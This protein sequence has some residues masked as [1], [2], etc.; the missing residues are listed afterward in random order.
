M[1]Q[2]VPVVNKGRGG[3]HGVESVGGK[4]KAK[5]TKY[6]QSPSKKSNQEE[7]P[8]TSDD[9]LSDYSFDSQGSL[10]ME[11]LELNDDDPEEEPEPPPELTE[12]EKIVGFE[13]SSRGDL[14]F[15]GTFYGPNQMDDPYFDHEEIELLG[16]DLVE[17]DLPSEPK[18][19]QLVSEIYTHSRQGHEDIAL[20]KVKQEKELLRLRARKYEVYGWFSYN[21]G[22]GVVQVVAIAFFLPMLLRTLAVQ[23]A[24]PYVG[25]PAAGTIIRCPYYK[26]PS[27]YTGGRYPTFTQLQ[28]SV[29]GDAYEKLRGF[30]LYDLDVFYTSRGL[31][32]TSFSGPA[33]SVYTV[34]NFSTLPTFVLTQQYR[35]LKWLE[36]GNVERGNTT[37]NN[38]TNST[39]TTQ[40][41]I[42]ERKVILGGEVES[43]F[44]ATNET[45]TFKNATNSSVV[46][47]QQNGSFEGNVSNSSN[48]SNISTLCRTATEEIHICTSCI[49]PKIIWENIL[50]TE[51]FINFSS[52]ME[53]AE[54]PTNVSVYDSVGG[55]VE[56]MPT[57]TNLQNR[58]YRG[59]IELVDGYEY[60]EADGHLN[61]STTCMLTFNDWGALRDEHEI[62][63]LPSM[64]WIHNPRLNYSC[65]PTAKKGNASYALTVPM[66]TTMNSTVY[67][68][69]KHSQMEIEF[70]VYNNSHPCDNEFECTPSAIWGLSNATNRSDASPL[71]AW[72]LNVSYPYALNLTDVTVEFLVNSSNK[73][74]IRNE[75]V[76]VRQEEFGMFYLTVKPEKWRFGS[77]TITVEIKGAE[78]FNCSNLNS[79]NSSLCNTTGF[80][81]NKTSA[82]TLSNTLESERNGS[83]LRN[84][85]FNLTH[86]RL[87]TAGLRFSFTVRVNETVCGHFVDFWVWRIRAV[88]YPQH[89][90]FVSFLA[91]LVVGLLFG[92]AGDY[93]CL[94]RLG[95]FAFSGFGSFCLLTFYFW[96]R[97]QDYLYAGI[98][99]VVL[100]AS[101]GTAA[102]YHNA[103]L[104]RLV[105]ADL[106]LNK[107]LET[108]NYLSDLIP[109]N[110]QYDEMVDRVS[111]QAFRLVYGFGAFGLFASYMYIAWSQYVS[112]V[113]DMSI[114][115]FDFLLNRLKYTQ[116]CLVE[117]SVND[118]SMILAFCGC[119]MGFFVLVNSSL[120]WTRWGVRCNK[121]PIWANILPPV[122]WMAFSI[123]KQGQMYYREDEWKLLKQSWKVL[124]LIFM[125][126]FCTNALTF[127]TTVL[128]NSEFHVNDQL[129]EDSVLKISHFFRM[130][131]LTWVLTISSWLGLRCF[132]KLQVT[133]EM[134]HIDAFMF[135]TALFQ[136]FMLYAL[137]ANFAE[138]PFG[139]KFVEEAYALTFFHGLWNG[140]LYAYGRSAFMKVVP[141]GFDAQFFT[142]YQ[143]AT[144]VNGNSWLGAKMVDN[145][146][147]ATGTV[148]L[149]YLFLFLFVMCI[150]CTFC[151]ACLS[152]EHGKRAA[153]ALT[154]VVRQRKF[155]KSWKHL[156]Q[157]VKNRHENAAVSVWQLPDLIHCMHRQVNFVDAIDKFALLHPKCSRRNVVKKA[158][159]ICRRE[160]QD[161]TPFFMFQKNKRPRV[162]PKFPFM[163]HIEINQKLYKMWEKTDEEERAVFAQKAEAEAGNDRLRYYVK[164]NVLWQARYSF[165]LKKL[166]EFAPH[167]IQIQRIARG[168]LCRKNVKPIPSVALEIVSA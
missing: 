76:N 50:W 29:P 89:V 153:R 62:V 24:C 39:W 15:D 165:E 33:G 94:R 84:L 41:C 133:F 32:V 2:I 117:P 67:D 45:V 140:P 77:S 120:S 102:V 146:F 56:R 57:Y 82:S 83:S 135:A 163:S 137:F 107:L 108:M 1:S 7:H 35:R 10:A 30:L 59:G 21:A 80:H 103:Y 139:L 74:L 46:C 113:W 43:L 87:E 37:A 110:Q 168:F 118:M 132:K 66:N 90:F 36:Y 166:P 4:G 97:P 144:G 17:I 78:P 119:W 126:F 136:F 48:S 100:V 27:N 95:L 23:Y 152:V 73:H 72:S 121:M 127:T 162:E 40:Q 164:R 88:D 134:L 25:L 58:S 124:L 38:L 63:Y 44:N 20:A 3:N 92:A 160:I 16:N 61:T 71:E 158:K 155:A 149:M 111:S 69:D 53:Y 109:F 167:A 86:F 85:T 93:C 99:T 145:E 79:T 112:G 156:R 13:D 114:S 104:T 154:R 68:I 65:E 81:Q 60:V 9:A 130:I 157:Q 123:F 6:I 70:M 131:L 115:L 19:S 47:L 26:M 129:P 49:K 91:Q 18:V 8:E 34:S 116:L 96:T 11:L 31:N 128:V 75:N 106:P 148:R 125:A 42:I 159:K 52:P 64:Q 150:N 161:P 51:D 138:L 142:L 55:L 5:L 28:R 22:W 143:S 151:C 101:F 54:Y 141:A 147:Q 105:Q 14:I 98:A 12:L 122:S